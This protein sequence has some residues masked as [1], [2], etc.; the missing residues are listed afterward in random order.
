M[1]FVPPKPRNTVLH[2]LLKQALPVAIG[3]TP[4]ELL[5]APFPEKNHRLTTTELPVI[6]LYAAVGRHPQQLEHRLLWEP[7]ADPII[8]FGNHL[9]VIAAHA[10]NSVCHAF[11]RLLPRDHSQFGVLGYGGLSGPETGIARFDLVF[12]QIRKQ[13]I[14][15][16]EAARRILA[17][18]G[19]ET[20]QRPTTWALTHDRTAYIQQKAMLSLA[21]AQRAGAQAVVFAG[22]IGSPL[23]QWKWD[24]ELCESLGHERFTSAAEQDV[25]QR[26]VT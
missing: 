23:E 6:A 14:S 13:H 2:D 1:Q 12:S 19:V 11:K 10:W 15:L 18:I 4:R 22:L 8:R 25:E 3:R 7:G 20:V 16:T 17:I 5:T 24:A 21:P 9:E 26:S